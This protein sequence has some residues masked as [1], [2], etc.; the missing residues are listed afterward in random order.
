MSILRLSQ[1]VAKLRFDNIVGRSDIDAAIA[2]MRSSQASIEPELQKRTREDPVSRLY[3]A[4]KDW[5]VKMH[6]PQVPYD[7]IDELATRVDVLGDHRRDI[8]KATCEEYEQIA[9]WTITRDRQGNIASVNFAE[10]DI[11]MV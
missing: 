5:A 6:N 7:T 3:L 2:L 10:E 4:I 9:V 11:N 8:I 1:A